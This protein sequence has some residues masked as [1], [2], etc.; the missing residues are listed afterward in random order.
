VTT[1]VTESWYTRDV[2]I[3]VRTH[4][5]VFM[6]AI[7]VQHQ[8]P[9]TAV[10]RGRLPR[11]LCSLRCHHRQDGW[12][13]T[14]SSQASHNAHHRMPEDRGSNYRR[15]IAVWFRRLRLSA[16]ARR[17]STAQ[18]ESTYCTK[19]QKQKTMFTRTQ[20]QMCYTTSART[21]SAWVPTVLQSHTPLRRGIAPNIR[22]TLPILVV[23]R[24]SGRK[25]SIL[26]SNKKDKKIPVRFI[27]DA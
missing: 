14:F 18:H 6:L 9:A 1:T 7:F 17:R 13:A 21:P 19:K 2:S 12:G 24:W 26:T 4:A 22:H 27:D 5:R 25:F 20:T 16:H 23:S 10:R 15:V 8:V 11:D 3:S